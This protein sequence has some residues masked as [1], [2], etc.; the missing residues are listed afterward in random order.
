MQ[1]ELDSLKL[2]MKELKLK[3]S[4]P[5]ALSYNRPVKFK[6]QDYLD[7]STAEMTSQIEF[8]LPVVSKKLGKLSEDLSVNKSL[9]ANIERNRVK[10]RL[11]QDGLSFQRKMALQSVK[12]KLDSQAVTL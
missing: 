6:A 4:Q 9:L 1:Q 8:D 11:Q 5:G 10:F 3:E 12:D 7:Y 2:Q